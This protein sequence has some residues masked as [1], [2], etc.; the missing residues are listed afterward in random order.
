MKKHINKDSNIF[1]IK[2]KKTL[3]AFWVNEIKICLQ[4]WTEFLKMNYI[5]KPTWQK[6]RS[7]YCVQIRDENAYYSKWIYDFKSTI[8]K[9]KQKFV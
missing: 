9:T 1:E 5:C 3:Y 4:E 6:R 2:R 7:H 8:Y